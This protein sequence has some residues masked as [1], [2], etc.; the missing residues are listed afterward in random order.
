MN[1]NHKGSLLIMFS[2][3]LWGV[4]GLFMQLLNGLGASSGHISFARMFFSFI[5][6]AAF[7][8]ITKGVKVFHIDRRGLLCS[9]LMGLFCQCI[10]NLSYTSSVKHNGMAVSAV[11]LYIAPVFVALISKLLFRE[12]F[13]ALKIF[14][15][16]VNVVGCAFA[17]TGGQFGSTAL[18]LIG[19]A[20][21]LLAALMY[22]LSSVIGR[23]ASEGHD[24]I[25]VNMY[26]FLFASI[27][28]GIISR[29][30]NG[31][32]TVLGAEFILY[33]SLLALISTVVPYVVYLKGISLISETSKVPVFASVE[34]IVAAL[35]GVVVLS[36]KMNFLNVFGILLVLISIWMI[37][38]QKNQPNSN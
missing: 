26:M 14:A 30:W 15:L 23:F 5:L 7:G 13:S 11:L 35:L 18:S 38:R 31:I 16:A 34:M 2:G 36:E 21:G 33:S 32:Y 17:A 19:L 4:Q 6:L 24:P 22:S 8:L 10:Y 37:S 28:V 27:F 20:L 9:F 12:K 25:S 3:V 1:S 29:P